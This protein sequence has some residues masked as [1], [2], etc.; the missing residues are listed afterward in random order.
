[1]IAAGRVAAGA[2]KR[3]GELIAPGVTTREIDAAVRRFIESHGAVPSFLGYGGF[4]A[5]ACISIGDTVIHGIPDGTQLCEGDVVSV[6]VGAYLDGFHGDTARTFAVGR[7]SSGAQKLLD[8]T[9]ECLRRGIAAALPGN[10]IGDISSAIQ[11]YA[12]QNGFSVVR[13]FVGHG[14]GR[15]LHEEPSVPN[16]GERGRGPRLTAGMALAI[17]PMIA[18][19]GYAV[20]VLR[21]GWTVKT[22][23]GS[24]SSHEEHSV[25]I[26]EQGARVLTA[27]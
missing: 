3:A 20:K 19:G 2:L 18:A 1:M 10:R 17:E 4:P 27:I 24:L 6:D 22:V 25:V 9:R 21:D 16:F 5:S 7:V 23:D 8:V 13:E 15:N 11:E 14:V 12:E 26:T